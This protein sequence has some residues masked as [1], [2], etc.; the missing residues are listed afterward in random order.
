[1][2][3][4]TDGLRLLRGGAPT[5]PVA[6][7]QVDPVAFQ[8]ACL[9]SFEA[10]QV[11]RGFAQTTMDNGAGVL[12]RFL[13]SCGRPAWEVTREDVDRVV[14]GLVGQGLSA[15]TRRGYVQTFK[16]FH[17]YLTA[18]K[19]SEIEA[20]FGI[21]IVDPVDEFNAARHVDSSS[22]SAT[23]P[24]DPQRMEEFFDFLKD[25]VAEPVST[26]P[27]AATTPC[28]GPCTSRGCEPRRRRRWTA[29]TCTSAA[30]PS[31]RSMSASARAPR[32]PARGHAGFRCWTG[33]TSSSA[34]ICRTS[35]LV[36]A[37]G[38]HCSATR[39]RADPP[40]HDPQPSGPPAGPGAASPR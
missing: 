36:W 9:R 27:P 28:S 29:P 26:R 37:M 13:V 32:P 23:A 10:S 20:A 34:G 6:G 14:A 24:P 8:D 19:S 35:P 1:M 12:E 22:P 7:P 31:G 16:G 30:G 3:V 11:A 15:A 39:G 21:R 17:A 25:R 4:V 5:A 2:C 38:R 40:R 33:S 18:R